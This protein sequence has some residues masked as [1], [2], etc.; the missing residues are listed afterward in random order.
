LK[1]NGKLFVEN[2]ESKEYHAH[3]LTLLGKCYLE[4]E[5]Y[6]DALELLDKALDIAKSIHREEDKSCAEIMM[7][8]ANCHAK[9]G[10]YDIALDYLTRVWGIH[11]AKEG[12][13]S[14]ACAHVYLEIAKIYA[15]KE[16]YQNAVDY[17]GRAIS[18]LLVIVLLMIFDVLLLDNFIENNNES[19]DYVANL[20]SSLS[21]MQEKLGDFDGYLK[22]LINV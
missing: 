7:L 17:Q 21:T 10:D 20:F 19:P 6:E 9:S 15:K 12:L 4:T 13:R 3:I 8:M 11:E 18:K 14:D 1:K 16:D 22:S 5:N 2:P